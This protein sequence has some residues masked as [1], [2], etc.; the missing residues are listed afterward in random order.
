MLNIRSM[1]PSLLLWKSCTGDYWP[2]E[3]RLV[4]KHYRDI[5]CPFETCFEQIFVM[6]VSGIYLSFA[7]TS[8]NGRTA[9]L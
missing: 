4:E 8:L 2:P 3:R 9:A 6:T 5:S 7:A 1:I